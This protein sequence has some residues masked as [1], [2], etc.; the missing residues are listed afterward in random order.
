MHQLTVVAVEYNS[1]NMT[2]DRKTVVI[3]FVGLQY[4]L[5]LI[6]RQ[7]KTVYSSSND[8]RH[9]QC[10]PSV[11]RSPGLSIT[12]RTT[13]TVRTN[14]RIYITYVPQSLEANIEPIFSIFGY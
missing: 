5:I 9:R 2:P 6:H 3:D 1:K 13:Q 12:D 4:A 11:D 7:Q 8:Q 14:L 10:R